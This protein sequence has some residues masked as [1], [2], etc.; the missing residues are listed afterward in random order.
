MS[1]DG[2][3]NPP[4]SSAIKSL[5]SKDLVF[6]K[7][8]NTFNR[9][10]IPPGSAQ[11]LSNYRALHCHKSGMP[12]PLFISVICLVGILLPLYLSPEHFLI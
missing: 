3:S 2:G 10:F 9:T 1:R 7:P 5:F 4:A 11:F 8:P 6:W 12:T